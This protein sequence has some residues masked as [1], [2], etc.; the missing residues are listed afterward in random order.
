MKN[1]SCLRLQKER[2]CLPCMNILTSQGR[3]KKMGWEEIAEKLMNIVVGFCTHC[4]ARMRLVE[5]IPESFHQRIRAPD[6]S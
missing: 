1:S 3:K 6:A 4:G 5:I 2:P